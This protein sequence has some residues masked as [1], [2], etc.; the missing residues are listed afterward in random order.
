MISPRAPSMSFGYFCLTL[1]L[2]WEDQQLHFLLLGT[3]M[4]ATAPEHTSSFPT[5]QGKQRH[6]PSGSFLLREKLFFP[7]LETLESVGSN[8]EV[9]S[10]LE[11]AWLSTEKAGFTRENRAHWREGQHMWTVQCLHAQGRPPTAACVN[12]AVKRA[13]ALAERGPCPERD[14]AEA[15]D[16]SRTVPA[17]SVWLPGSRV[18]TGRSRPVLEVWR[19]DGH[20]QYPGRRLPSLRALERGDVHQPYWD[21]V[22]NEEVVR[23]RGRELW[24]SPPSVLPLDGKQLRTGPVCLVLIAS[25]SQH[26]AQC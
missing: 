6:V 14:R 1:G 23:V 11:A 9:Y 22:D 25:C 5:I 17:L 10:P 15:A 18:T 4:A 13:T 19:P 24:A 2:H 16:C 3:R 26:P 8:W 12:I 7:P 20:H 21:L